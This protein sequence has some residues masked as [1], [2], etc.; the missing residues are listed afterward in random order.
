MKSMFAVVTLLLAF[1]LADGE[2]FQC[3]AASGP[4]AA[5][6]TVPSAA[7]PSGRFSGTVE[8]Y[9][10]DWCGYCRKAQSYLK[11]RGIP[12]VTY[13]IEKDAAAYQRHKD[14]GGGGVPLVVI[15]SHRISGFSPEKMEYYLNNSK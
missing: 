5:R 11:S 14:L 3:L 10:T 12:Y 15:G 4:A 7:S 1:T 8:L 9:V 2:M 13:D 6:D